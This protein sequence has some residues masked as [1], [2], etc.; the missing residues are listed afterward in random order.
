[1]TNDFEKKSHIHNADPLD[2]LLEYAICG[3]AHN[4]RD[5]SYAKQWYDKVKNITPAMTAERLADILWDIPFYHNL[6]TP[7][8]M[9]EK[10][11][12][13][14]IADELL[15]RCEVRDIINDKTG[16]RG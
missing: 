15:K 1:M 3:L 2:L 4:N 6:E 12:Y 14:V 8:G 10:G 7:V 11:Y 9:I 13:K 5:T 16:I